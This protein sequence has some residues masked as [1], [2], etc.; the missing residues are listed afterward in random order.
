MIYSPKDLDNK[1]QMYRDEHNELCSNAWMMLPVEFL[2]GFLGKTALMSHYGSGFRVAEREEAPNVAIT[3]KIEAE[4]KQ[5]P[6]AKAVGFSS[7]SRCQCYTQKTTN[8]QVLKPESLRKKRQC[9]FFHLGVKMQLVEKGRSE[10]IL[11]GKCS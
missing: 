7:V 9:S 10:C 4:L 1:V 3:I 2:H 6:R 5:F 8:G 11:E